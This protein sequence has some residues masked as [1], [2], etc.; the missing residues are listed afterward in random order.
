MLIA[1]DERNHEKTGPLGLEFA[2]ALYH[3]KPA[4]VSFWMRCMSV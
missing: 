3:E 4:T 2:D 1:G